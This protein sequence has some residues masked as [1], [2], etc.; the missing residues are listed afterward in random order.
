MRGCLLLL[1][2]YLLGQATLCSAQTLQIRHGDPVPLEVKSMYDAGLKY[3]AERQSESGNWVDTGVNDG[4][5]TDGLCLLAFLSNGDD[6]NFGPYAEN[7]RRGLRHMLTNQQAE[8]GALVSG[9]AEVNMYHQGFG[10]LALAE[11]YG[12]VNE[13]LLW[14]GVADR[15]DRS[16]GKGLEAA[17]RCI[18][19]AQRKNSFHGWRYTPDSR[20]ADVSVSGANIVALLAA[21][22][23]GIEVPDE[24]LQQAMDL[25][26]QSTDASGAVVYT[27]GSGNGFDL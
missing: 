13:D 2:G 21:R 23:A 19:D 14:Q 4:A 22:N 3:L 6:P 5:G 15:G 11:A 25:L 9:R 10:T 7:I 16:I 27:V 1:I 24:S 26:K 8:T 17:V 18:L 20:D 12:A